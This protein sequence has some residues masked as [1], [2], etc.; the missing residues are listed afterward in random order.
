MKVACRVRV[1]YLMEQNHQFFA[2]F[3]NKFLN[4]VFNTNEKWI[5]TLKV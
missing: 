1:A 2:V 5:A 3:L 4:N